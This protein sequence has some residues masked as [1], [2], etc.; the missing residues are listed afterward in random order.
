[1]AIKTKIPPGFEDTVPSMKSAN[2][3]ILASL[4][5]VGIVPPE[6][7][8]FDLKGKDKGIAAAVAYPI[9]GILKYH[10][11]TDWDWR[12]S[13][14]PSVSLNNDAGYTITL[15]EFDPR[16][17]DDQVLLDGKPADGRAF[18]RVVHSLEIVRRMV[19]IQSHARV[20]S[21]NIVKASKSG[22][23]LGTSA[24]ASAALA[25]A[26]LAASLGEDVIQNTRLLSCFSRMLSGSGS[27]SATGGLSLWLSYPGINHEDS[28]SVRLDNHEQLK[29]LR[30]ITIPIDSRVGLKTEEAHRDAPH[31]PFFRAW[32]ESRREEIIECISASQK[33]DWKTIGQ[34]AELDSIRLHG[35]TMSGSREN[36]VFAWEPENIPLF[37][38]CNDLRQEGIPVYF[39]TDTGPTTVLLTHEEF[40]DRVIERIKGLKMDLE[41]IRG[42]IAGPAHLVDIQRAKGELGT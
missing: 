37:R 8:S 15:V 12:I 33:G 41:V 13:Y 9:Q 38:M 31:S 27:R 3:Y 42:E 22:K 40:A 5:N 36:K 39:S 32:M 18:D 35:V 14:M 10:G 17:E 1:M 28:F 20:T 29:D 26:A 21:R 19:G 4:Q 6:Y 16:F 23:G 11:M 7:P 34:L 2:Q 24:S 25:T 30:L